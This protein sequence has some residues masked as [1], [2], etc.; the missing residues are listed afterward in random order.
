M[1][2]IPAEI[3]QCIDESRNMENLLSKLYIRFSELYGDDRDFWWAM[4]LEEKAHSST[5]DTCEKLIQALGMPEGLVFDDVKALRRSNLR[6][7][8]ILTIADEELERETAYTFAFK[9]ELS[10]A[11]AHYQHLM[12]LSTDD[13][14]IK[15]VQSI[16]RDYQD[17]AMR[18]KSHMQE[19]RISIR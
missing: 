2:T 8:D 16:G 3:Q 11:E 9:F 5:M 13:K 18:I 1:P 14:I 6:I 15:T 12:H 17:H 10:T 7:M 4:A 19:L